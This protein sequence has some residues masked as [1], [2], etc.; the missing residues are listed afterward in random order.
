MP[1]FKRPSAQ[2]PGLLELTFQLFPPA[3]VLCQRGH[4]VMEAAADRARLPFLQFTGER[5]R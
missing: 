3:A 1:R 2:G 4:W 5:Q